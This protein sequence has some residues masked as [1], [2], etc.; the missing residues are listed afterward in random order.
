MVAATYVLYPVAC[1][2]VAAVVGGTRA[3]YAAFDALTPLQS[4]VALGPVVVGEELVWRGVV[5]GALEQRLGVWRGALL[6]TLLYALSH[7]P[8][9]SPLLVVTALACG[10][11]WGALRAWTGTL[12]ATLASHLLWDAVVLLIRPLVHR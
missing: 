6:A 4:G 12:V 3:L 10:L 7:L 2:A 8:A 11:L 9:G 5:Q 1:S